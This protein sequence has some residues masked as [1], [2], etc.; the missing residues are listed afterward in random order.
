MDNIF[1]TSFIISFIYSIIVFFELRYFQKED[2]AMK[3]I[4]KEGLIVY[5]S[6]ILGV[7]LVDQ[8]KPEIEKIIQESPPLVFVDNP[9]F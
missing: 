8:F 1:V 2:K 3:D 9:P 7:F 5:L 4:I 6:V